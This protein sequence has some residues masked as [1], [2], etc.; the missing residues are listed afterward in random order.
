M[1][2]KCIFIFIC[3]LIIS[4][5][6]IG[7]IEENITP[8]KITERMKNERE[9]I[10]DVSYTE[11]LNYSD[12]GLAKTSELYFTYKKPNMFKKELKDSAGLKKQLTVSNGT[13]TWIY[14]KNKNFVIIS[15]SPLNMVL[16]S[17]YFDLLDFMIENCTIELEA[18]EHNNEKNKNP[19]YRINLIPNK[20]RYNLPG[21]WSYQ[22]WVESENW[23]PLK[24]ITYNDGKEVSVIEYQ[25][26]MI[27]AGL[28]DDDFI[29]KIP[30]GT[31]IIIR[32]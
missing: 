17:T 27:N 10:Q 13:T 22:L 5:I 7:C 4:F 3:I 19:I 11:V 21:N 18:I 9:K 29:F 15:A 14:D 30:N 16:E 1:K 26:I 2:T 12:N 28:K 23:V 20:S 25:D 24:I 31:E 6:S 8:E 32:K